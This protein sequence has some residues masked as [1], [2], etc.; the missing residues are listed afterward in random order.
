MMLLCDF[1]LLFFDFEYPALVY[2]GYAEVGGI[3]GDIR[4]LR[5][6][7]LIRSSALLHRGGLYFLV[8]FFIN[9]AIV[10]PSNHFS[11]DPH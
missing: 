2:M 10:C 7:S 5:F 6:F 8:D 1:D 3:L 9:W 4:R 11:Y